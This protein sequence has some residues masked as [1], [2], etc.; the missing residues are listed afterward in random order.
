MAS[1]YISILDSQICGVDRRVHLRGR[2]DL[3]FM[4]DHGCLGCSL[5]HMGLSPMC[6]ALQTGRLCLYSGNDMWQLGPHECVLGEWVC[7]A[8]YVFQ[9]ALCL[10]LEL[11]F[12][13]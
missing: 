2:E 11:P 9:Q 6:P 13:A 8:L 7:L 12:A 3:D 10:P 5:A 1:I 4:E